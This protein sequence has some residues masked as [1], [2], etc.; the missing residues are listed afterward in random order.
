VDE[1]EDEGRGAEFFERFDNGPIGVEILLNFARLD[2]KDVNQDCDVG[3]D[4][5]AL[6]GKVGFGK[7]GLSVEV[8]EL[9][10]P[11]CDHQGDCVPATI[12]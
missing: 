10:Y 8:L 3:E 12:P 7:G 4:G 9:A 5:F 11:I 2:I 1:A 6:C